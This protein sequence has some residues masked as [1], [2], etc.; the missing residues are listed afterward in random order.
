[1]FH[2]LQNEKKYLYITNYSSDEESLCKMEIKCLF[3]KP[4]ND[5]YL[6]SNIHIDPSR[7]PFIK[8]CI[9]VMYT[10]ET[11]EI[12]IEQIN[13][14]ELTSNKYK[15]AYINAPNENVGFHESRRIEFEIGFSILGECEMKKPETIFGITKIANTW[16]FGKCES[17][18]SEW[19]QRNK[20]PFSYSN[21]LK[22][23][24]CRAIVNI[25]VGNN[26]NC[27]VVDPC[28]GIGTVLIEAIS[29]H[30]NIKGYE[31]NPLIGKN[32]KTNLRY[33]GYEDVIT[34][35]DMNN[36][37]NKYDVAIVDLPYG[38]FTQITTA[39][40]LAIM[41]STR[42][43]AAKMVIVTFDDM[44]EQIKSVGFRIDDRCSVSKGTFQRHIYICS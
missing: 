42:R 6:F 43:I 36:I 13:N 8:K 24:V 2:L 34:I 31:I 40:Q 30:I 9:S 15:V 12:I 5:K 17:N 35:G 16:I 37:Q 21:A 32:A 28:C 38:I 7:S 41:S 4:L 19:L 3:N 20:K 25:A 11:M 26:L 29:M 27:S 22:V 10:G 44:E 1:M 39:Q 18:T 33:F 23:N 14:D